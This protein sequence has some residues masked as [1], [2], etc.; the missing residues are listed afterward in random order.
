MTARTGGGFSQTDCQLACFVASSSWS[1]NPFPIT[2]GKLLSVGA[3]LV[4]GNG[5]NSFHLPFNGCS[6]NSKRKLNHVALCG[7]T[8]FTMSG[9]AAD[10]QRPESDE[11]GR[12]VRTEMRDRGSNGVDGRRVNQGFGS[13][14]SGGPE[15]FLRLP[16]IA[17]LDVDQ[18]GTLSAKEI[19][20][21]AVALKRLDKNG[22]GKID[23]REM[24]STSG[25]GEVDA[26]AMIDRLMQRD[27]DGDG[28]LTYDEMPGLL[29]RIVKRDD[30]N[31][32]GKLSRE[33]VVKSV[34]ALIRKREGIRDGANPGGQSPKQPPLEE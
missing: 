13:G 19:E 24:F 20:N 27:K 17:V 26:K 11:G 2:L 1:F 9:V 28:F 10:A 23:M 6:M 14:R 21:A 4:R 5:D 29:T 34:E 33:E 3:E 7:L 8:L 25:A 16:V 12:R 22:D 15:M 30:A 31:G 32:D 18:D